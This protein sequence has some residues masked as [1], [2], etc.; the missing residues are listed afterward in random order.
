MVSVMNYYYLYDENGAC[1]VICTRC[2][3]TLGIADGLS[4]AKKLQALHTCGRNNDRDEPKT[5]PIDRGLSRPSA[6][7]PNQVERL[8]GTSGTLHN[9]NNSILFFAVVALLYALPTVLELLA[10]KH[11]NPWFAVILPGDVIGCACLITVFRMPKTGLALYLLLTIC[12]TTL[13]ESKVVAARDLLW[14]V[15]S[16]PTL[17]AVVLILRARMPSRFRH[18]R[19]SK[20]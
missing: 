18:L 9:L 11:F 1:E 3:A 5:I 10:T 8:F 2:F 7:R 4:D 16:V 19:F 17:I 14:I 12:E 15:D 20:L 6:S 13:Y